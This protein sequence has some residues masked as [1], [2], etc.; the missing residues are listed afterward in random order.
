MN[1]NHQKPLVV[2][3]TGASGSVYGLRFVKAIT[4]LGHP[5]TLT[6][7]H[8]AG[9][10]IREELGIEI[11]VKDPSCVTKLF[12]N[13]VIASLPAT[14][15]CGR[16]KQSRGH[17]I[18]S[19]LSAP[20]ND[21]PSILNLISYY[22]EHE[23][24]APIASGSYPARGM[25]IVPSSTTTFSKIANGISESLIERAAECMI[26]EGR[27]LVIVPRETP[28][29]AIHLE[30]LLKLARL[31]VRVVPAI[32]AFY[33]GAQKIE[34]L[35]DFVIGKVLDQLDIPHTL[36]RRWVGSEAESKIKG[37]QWTENWL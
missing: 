32:P 14:N 8:A 16:A 37:T 12:S 19:S 6:L 20:R 36:Y 24:T 3:I 1:A 31:G 2:G 15:L 21:E 17:E 22:P 23:M 4:E 26:K 30:N 28:L 34:E 9:L 29:S 27:K 13:P 33:S 10:V 7:S 11:D 18:A 25:V 5:I 35:V